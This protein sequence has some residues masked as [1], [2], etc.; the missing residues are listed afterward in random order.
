MP[1]A[2]PGTGDPAGNIDEVSTPGAHSPVVKTSEVNH[3]TQLMGWFQVYPVLPE[4]SSRATGDW[5]GV[6]TCRRGWGGGDN[7]ARKPPG[8]A[9]V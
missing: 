3:D 5:K 9:P 1:G 8:R 4:R 6:S 2:G 7:E